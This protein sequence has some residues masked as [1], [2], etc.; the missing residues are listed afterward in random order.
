MAEHSHESPPSGGG[1]GRWVSW[2]FVF[3]ALYFM[4]TEH[5]AHAFQYLPYLLL[6][7]C[8]LLHLLHG[9]GGHGKDDS[10]GRKEGGEKSAPPGAHG[11]H[12]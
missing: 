3:V 10:A 8:P 4:L 11:G 5:R 12:H 9:H 2:G 6:A 7:A 1:Y